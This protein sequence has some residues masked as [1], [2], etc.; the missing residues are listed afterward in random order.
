MKKRIVSIAFLLAL[1]LMLAMP[2]FADELVA[3]PVV[4]EGTPSATGSALNM[5]RMID[6]AGVLYYEEAEQFGAELDSLSSKYDCDVAVIIVDSLEGYT[7]EGM[8]DMFFDTYMYGYNDGGDERNGVLLLISVGDREWWTKKSGQARYDVD[9]VYIGDEMLPYLKED[10]YASA[11]EVYIR[12]CDAMLSG[13][14]YAEP[15]ADDSASWYL[16]PGSLLLGTGGS[17]A[18]MNGQ[19]SKLKSVRSQ[20]AAEKY[21]R[22]GSMNVASS[23]DIFLFSRTSRSARASSSSGSGSG[24]S[25]GSRGSRSDRGSRGS[26][27]KF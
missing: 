10:D 21:V 23:K 6:E 26:G 11:I 14:R 20:R 5:P 8:A 3:L 9:S 25:S 16:A 24:Y 19:K 27:G 15:Q 18:Y 7:A 1:C 17:F 22:L 4:G 12:E 2:V 13:E